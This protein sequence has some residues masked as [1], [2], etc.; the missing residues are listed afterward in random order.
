MKRKEFILELGSEIR[1][2]KINSNNKN[3][4]KL[5]TPHNNIETQKENELD[6]SDRKILKPVFVVVLII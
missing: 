4:F 2:N 6:I 1:K 5:D 3:T